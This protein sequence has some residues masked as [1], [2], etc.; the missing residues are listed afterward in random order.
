[1]EPK[2][3]YER[4]RRIAEKTEQAIQIM[5][6]LLDKKLDAINKI[7]ED[8]SKEIGQRKQEVY[9]KYELDFFD[10]VHGEMPDSAKEE[11]IKLN[12]EGI[13]KI[14]RKYFDTIINRCK[15]QLH[16]L[17][18][19]FHGNN[20][21]IDL[22]NQDIAPLLHFIEDQNNK[23]LS[24]VQKR[25]LKASLLGIKALM[26]SASGQ[27]KELE[28]IL[29]KQIKLAA[30]P[31]GNFWH[32]IVTLIIRECEIFNTATNTYGYHIAKLHELRQRVKIIGKTAIAS[33]THSVRS[34][35]FRL[36]Y[37]KKIT[38]GPIAAGIAYGV[39][40]GDFIKGIVTSIIGMII[41]YVF[42]MGLSIKENSKYE[43]K[44]KI[45]DIIQIALKRPK[46]EDKGSTFLLGN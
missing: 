2:E 43:Y 42:L 22:Y 20:N 39:K 37:N 31:S 11:L 40:E 16:V 12:E 41:L 44:K 8:I 35:N 25:D 36:K 15:W 18:L 3:A 4:A 45:D 26:E 46:I 21:L 14:E 30:E 17:S 33:I 5:F 19:F 29:N 28:D 38:T 27:L 23:F 7:A 24:N 32:D 34:A 10:L 6:R 1:M 13:R 9:K